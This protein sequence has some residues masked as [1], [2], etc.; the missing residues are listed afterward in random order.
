MQ[1]PLKNIM[2]LDDLNSKIDK[3]WKHSRLFDGQN[4]K[5]QKNSQF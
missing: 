2:S 1:S 3:C 5:K 4:E